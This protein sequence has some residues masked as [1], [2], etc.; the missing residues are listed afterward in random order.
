M[1][2]LWR[3]ARFGEGEEE[4]EEER[5]LSLLAGSLRRWASVFPSLG[6]KLPFF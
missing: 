3:S 6:S 5:D 4:E 2:E 1:E